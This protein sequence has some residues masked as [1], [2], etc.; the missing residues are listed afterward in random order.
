MKKV[1]LGFLILSLLSLPTTKSFSNPTPAPQSQRARLIQDLRQQ[2]L[3]KKH[4]DFKAAKKLLQAKNVPFDPDIL[5]TSDW[6]TTLKPKFAEMREMQELRSG[7]NKI[8]GAQLAHTLYLPEQVELTGDTVILANNL[9]FAGR[10]A[11]VRGPFNLYIYLV[12]RSGLLGTSLEQAMRNAEPQFT[13]VSF[14]SKR[15]LPLLPM[16][17]NGKVTIDTHAFGR[18][19][20]LNGRVKNSGT[21]QKGF[22]KAAYQ[23]TINNSGSPGADG[24]SPGQGGTGSTGTT[25]SAGNNGACGS[26]SSVNGANGTGGGIGGVGVTPS[27]GGNGANGGNGGAIVFDLGDFPFGSYT[28]LS[29]GGNGGNGG[30]GGT[31]GTGGNGGQGGAGGNGAN[32]ACDQGGSGAGGNGG[33]GGTAGQGGSGST[34]GNGGNGGSGGNITV[35]Y[36]L[37]YGTTFINTSSNGGSGGLGAPG[38]VGGSAGTRGNGGNGGL[39]GGAS[40]CPNQGFGGS[41]GAP[42]GEAGSGGSGASGNGGSTGSNGN[43]TLIPRTSCLTPA[44]DCSIYGDPPLIWR[45]YPTCSCVTRPSP[46]MFDIAGNGFQMTDAPNGVNFDLDANGAAEKL[47]W[48]A[49]GS[50][51]ALLFLDR[52]GNSTADSGAELFGNYTPQPASQSPNGFIALAEYDKTANGGDGNGTIDSRDAIFAELRVW[53][54]ANHNGVSEPEEVH[55]LT[56]VGI[57]AMS[58]AYKKSK[59]SDQ[60]DNLFYYRAKIQTAKGSQVDRWACDVFLLNE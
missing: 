18:T 58:L 48:T 9:V 21:N 56:D 49:A 2:D 16:I 8:K 35:T 43:I 26:T 4:A 14:S 10:D 41:N 32:C 22:V 40:I 29:N 19:E 30:T 51:D 46:I 52:N 13:P 33:A 55:T 12:E 50:D 57:K 34:G 42:G 39:S 25:G 59:Q 27:V 1:A 6:R 36:P 31:G 38:G 53:Q 5:L 37:F 44:E 54:D 24:S 47:S 45:G 15:N 17:A 7:N 23:F 3:D 11:V 20:W 60:Y 28:F